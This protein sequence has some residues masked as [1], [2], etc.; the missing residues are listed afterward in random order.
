MLDRVYDSFGS[1]CGISL[2]VF[3]P[4]PF[5]LFLHL[6]HSLRITESVELLYLVLFDGLMVSEST[7]WFESAEC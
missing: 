2:G 7:E 6:S 1:L 4:C 5:F 3:V